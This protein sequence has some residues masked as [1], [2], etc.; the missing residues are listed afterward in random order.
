MDITWSR[1]GWEHAVHDNVM[2]SLEPAGGIKL[3]ARNASL[4]WNRAVASAGAVT[5]DSAAVS[6]WTSAAL[7]ATGPVGIRIHYVDSDPC[8]D[9]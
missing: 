1:F 2:T 3:A 5:D 6:N 4:L 8:F 9:L 7:N